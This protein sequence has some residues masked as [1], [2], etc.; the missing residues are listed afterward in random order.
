MAGSGDIPHP[1][2][3]QVKQQ[4]AAAQMQNKPK[5]KPGGLSQS[6]NEVI[7]TMKKLEREGQRVE[8]NTQALM[9]YLKGGS[10]SEVSAEVLTAT[11]TMMAALAEK[12]K[13]KKKRIRDLYFR[14]ARQTS[15]SLITRVIN[16]FKPKE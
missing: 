16:T 10:G 15:T 4:E 9:D 11:A 5:A 3:E 8:R 6:L 14:W 1:H 13:T 2:S 7:A 12:N